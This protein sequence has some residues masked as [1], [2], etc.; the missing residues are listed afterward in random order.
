MS[1][2]PS[3]MFQVGCICCYCVYFDS[4]CICVFLVGFASVVGSGHLSGGFTNV[5]GSGDLSG[6]FTS[7]RWSVW[8]VPDELYLSLLCWFL[9][10]L[11]LCISYRIYQCDWIR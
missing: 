9:L 10:K 8:N 2:D 4:N 1:G 6:G 5:I 7:V 3:G 11:Y